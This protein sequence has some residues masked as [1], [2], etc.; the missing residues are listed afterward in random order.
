[1]R[2]CRPRL[3]DLV[4]ALEGRSDPPLRDAAVEELLPL[5]RREPFDAVVEH[6]ARRASLRPVLFFVVGFRR[7]RDPIN[8]RLGY[9][10]A[11]P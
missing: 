8:G 1:L 9:S 3:R 4:D 2:T 11:T 6:D 5:P 7:V 10:S